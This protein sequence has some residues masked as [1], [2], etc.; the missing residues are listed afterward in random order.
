[1][2]VVLPSI[3]ILPQVADLV[4]PATFFTIHFHS[5]LVHLLAHGLRHLCGLSQEV[6]K[7]KPPLLQ[8]NIQAGEALWPW[9]C[10]FSLFTQPSGPGHKTSPSSSPCVSPFRHSPLYTSHPI[11]R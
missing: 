7:L 6:G 3:P 4:L 9:D 11:C 10:P 1:M 2:A 8:K 5:L